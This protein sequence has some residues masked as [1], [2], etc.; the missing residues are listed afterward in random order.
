MNIKD[1]GYVGFICEA[2]PYDMMLF[3]NQGISNWQG[4]HCIWVIDGMKLTGDKFIDSTKGK[5][6]LLNLTFVGTIQVA[7]AR[8]RVL[9][10]EG[11]KRKK[12]V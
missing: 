4:T 8:C 6:V 5:P 9:R 10:R 3:L 1:L 2:L 12:L 11:T 7:V